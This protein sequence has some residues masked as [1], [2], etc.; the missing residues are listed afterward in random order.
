MASFELGDIKKGWLGPEP[1][2]IE[3]HK[4]KVV[5]DRVEEIKNVVVHRFSMGDVEDPDLYAAPSMIEWEKSQIGQWVKK[6]AIETPV[7]YR[8]LDV[9]SMG[10]QYLIKAKFTG[11][12]LT[13]WYLKYAP[14]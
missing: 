3:H 4:F 6:N 8:Q 1:N 13:E 9:S 10:Y 7:W 2:R 12:A 11:P 5:N 14:K